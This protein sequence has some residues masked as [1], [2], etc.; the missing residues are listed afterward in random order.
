MEV[1]VSVPVGVSPGD[2]VEVPFDDAVAEEEVV[3][4]REG[5]RLGVL[6]YERVDVLVL[7]GVRLGDEV[8]G[9]VCV[10][11]PEAA[12]LGV[13]EDVG[14]DVLVDDGVAVGVEVCV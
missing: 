13:C 4:V 10:E 2:F 5:D 12:Y 9:T 1:V 7:G 8:H 11:E 14:V 6:V 3:A